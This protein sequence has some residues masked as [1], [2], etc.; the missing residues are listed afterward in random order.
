MTAINH[1]PK[2]DESTA[3][4]LAVFLDGT[5]NSESSYTNVAK[6]YNLTTLQNNTNI[7][8]SYIKGVGTDGKVLGMAM[9]WGVGHDVREAYLFLVNNYQHTRHDEI[10]VFGFSRGAYAARILAALV[11]VAGIPDLS[12]LKNDK[13]RYNLIN[14]IY[15]AYKGDKTLQERRDAVASVLKYRPVPRDI[16]FLGIWDTVEALGTPDYTE[17]YKEPNA[18]Y[19]DQLCNVKKAAHALAIDDDRARIFTPILLTSQHLVS[20]CDFI[21]INDVVDEVWF[22]GAHADVGGGYDDTNI[23]G[24]SLNWMITK[25]KKYDLLPEGSSVYA[26]YLGKT[27]DPEAGLFSLVYRQRSRDLSGYVEHTPYY[28]NKLNIHRSVLK[29]LEHKKPQ[30]FEFQWMDKPSFKNCFTQTSCGL[31][32]KPESECFN[33]IGNETD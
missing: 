33:I 7:R 26:D 28:K 6:L 32:Y 14:D 11:Y 16:T 19:E 9:G 31:N 5:A 13:E 15:D 27:H 10:Y 12:S 1:Q 20:T 23:S 21:V 24:E 18:R 30:D 2:G 29:R 22:S 4:N 8:T 3:K 25:L 17:N